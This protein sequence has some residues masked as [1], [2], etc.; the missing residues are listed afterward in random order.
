MPA[1]SPTA[2]SPG[3]AERPVRVLIADDHDLVRRMLRRAITGR[4][5]MDIVAEA[6][7]G[8]TAVGLAR[9]LE[10]DVVVLDVAMPGMDGMQAAQAIRAALPA[11]R[12]LIFSAFP[13]QD[14]SGS[15][16]AAG[17]DRYLEKGAGFP[18]A[19]EA[20]AELAGR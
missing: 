10:P 5:G 8:A 12:I 6:A 18:A 9:A 7:E 11:C 15:A 3:A 16:L 20:V 1:T 4:G 14:T 13:A 17:A 2:M 19:A